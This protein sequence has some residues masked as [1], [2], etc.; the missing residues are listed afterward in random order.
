L[1]ELEKE[2][3]LNIEAK[4]VPASLAV[5]AAQQRKEAHKLHEQVNGETPIFLVAF[6]PGTWGWPSNMAEVWLG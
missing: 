3:E 1:G 6:P 2:K 5:E 4:D